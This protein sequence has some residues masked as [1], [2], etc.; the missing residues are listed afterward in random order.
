MEQFIQ[1]P[2][3]EEQKTKMATVFAELCLKSVVEWP[4]LGDEKD[5]GY[6]GG[7]TF[8]TY[9]FFSGSDSLAQSDPPVLLRS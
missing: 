8:G 2:P 3:S 9:F 1:Q 7:V 6:W 4:N 5:R